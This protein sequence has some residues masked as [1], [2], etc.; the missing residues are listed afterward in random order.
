MK[1]AVIGT[2]KIVHD[3]LYALSVVDEVQTA[4]IFGRP[5]SKDKAEALAR[6]Y[7]IGE[8]Y[9]DYDELLVKT[10]ADTVYIGL[11]NS[12]HYEYAKKALLAGK[13]VILEKPFTLTSREAEELRDLAV[14]QQLFLFEA[15]TTLHTR[16]FRK[17]EAVLPRLGP[18]KMVLAN[19]S[20]Y[21]SHY[22]EYRRGE[23]AACFDPQLNGGA[24]NDINVYNI[25]YCAALFGLPQAV[26]YYPQ[27][28][29]NGVDTSGVLVLSY[30]GF[31]AVCSA[32]KDSDSP[33]FVS[34]QGEKGW[35]RVDDKPNAAQILDVALAEKGKA[36]RDA[37]GASV[38]NMYREHVDNRQ[39]HHRMCQEFI[40][41]AHIMAKKDYAQRDKLLAETVTVVKILEIAHHSQE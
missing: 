16:V 23:V 26:Q 1:L 5:H 6:Q 4:A 30:P 33:C 18:V 12:V 25:H 29:F 14:R 39:Q 20:Q 15:I 38:R 3:A 22:D 7:A 37:A 11:V 21:S 40:D 10:S 2:G 13:H 28:G 9:T 8:V 27:R 34:I 31:T 35:L 17:I 32:A 36:G 24:L 41:F 19:F